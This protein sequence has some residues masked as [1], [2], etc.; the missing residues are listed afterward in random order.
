MFWVCCYTITVDLPWSDPRQFFDLPPAEKFVTWLSYLCHIG[1]E[2]FNEA[3]HHIFASV[4]SDFSSSNYRIIQIKWFFGKRTVCYCFYIHNYASASVNRQTTERIS[5]HGTECLE[6]SN[7]PQRQRY[8]A[9]QYSEIVQ[10][11]FCKFSSSII[12]PERKTYDR[13]RYSVPCG[14]DQGERPDKI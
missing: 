13:S 10:H 6:R 3:L 12:H 11:V 8:P 14:S 4:V 7:A 9:P 5:Y 1:Q 2:W